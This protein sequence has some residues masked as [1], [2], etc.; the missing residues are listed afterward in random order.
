MVNHTTDPRTIPLIEFDKSGRITRKSSAALRELGLK[1]CPQ[2]RTVKPHSAFYK[3]I[4]R[5][6]GCQNRC[7]I[8]QDY[9]NTV[10]VDRNK[11]DLQRYKKEYRKSNRS[12]IAEYMRNYYKKNR[13]YVNSRNRRYYQSHTAETLKR[14]RRRRARK[15]GAEGSHTSEDLKRLWQEQDAKC[16]YCGCQL[17]EDY[18]HLDHVIPLSRGGSEWP[19]NLAWA[20]PPCNLSKH[21]KLLEEWLN[22]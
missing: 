22:G 14:K 21:N 15:L 3:S 7:Q 11:E 1:F 16:A 2:C 8:C 4:G 6:D 12:A 13:D 17:S 18:R 19:E 9:V 5:V 20:C 10:W